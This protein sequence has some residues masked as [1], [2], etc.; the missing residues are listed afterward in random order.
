MALQRLIN[1]LALMNLMEPITIYFQV[2]RNARRDINGR[3]ETGSYR[4]LGE[5]K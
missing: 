1:L 4:K 2:F 5:G 3:P